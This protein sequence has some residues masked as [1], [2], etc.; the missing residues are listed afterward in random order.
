VPTTALDLG[1]GGGVPGLPLALHWPL[2]NWV[3]LD[4]NERRTAWLAEAVQT[5]DLA[6]RVRVV[7]ARAEE[8]GRDSTLR[9][10]FDVVTA[11]SFGPPAVT[12][13]CASPFLRIGGVLVVSEPPAEV[14]RWTVDGLAQLGLGI[15]GRS[16]GAPWMQVLVQERPC[17][18]R[19]P[20]RVGI[21]AKRPLF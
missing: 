11:R 1:S 21:P 5:L 19:F 10:G 18:E 3:L 7:R 14:G 17:P 13:E 2:S 4:G 16:S 12:A 15:G 8:A 6:D 9:G 20:R